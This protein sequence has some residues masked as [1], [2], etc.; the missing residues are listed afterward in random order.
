MGSIWLCGAEHSLI[1]SNFC[2]E[3]QVG[4]LSVVISKCKTVD[5]ILIFALSALIFF[6]VSISDGMMF[7]S[8]CYEM[9][10]VINVNIPLI[11]TKH[12]CIF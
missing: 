3:L 9:V 1:T 5:L 7:T 11:M 4:M 2:L 10:K 6:S 8:A 12:K